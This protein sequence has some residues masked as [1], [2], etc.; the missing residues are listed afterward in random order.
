MT[1]LYKAVA[2]DEDY[3]DRDAFE[4]VIILVKMIEELGGT[5]VNP[6]KILEYLP[7]DIQKDVKEAGK[8]RMVK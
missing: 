1:K 2:N 8:K 6:E 4:K 7:S 5:E 3:R